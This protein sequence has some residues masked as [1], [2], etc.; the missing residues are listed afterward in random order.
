MT[1]DYNG[2]KKNVKDFPHYKHQ[3]VVAKENPDK[4][5]TTCHH[6]WDS[7]SAEAPKAC[8]TCHGKKKDGD[9]PKI[10]SAYHKQ[11]QSCHEAMEAEGKPAGPTK[12]NCK[13]CHER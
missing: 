8:K 11:C 10:M 7:S 4:K 2:E 13:G 12:K 3:D 5:C 6:K 1:L 9:K